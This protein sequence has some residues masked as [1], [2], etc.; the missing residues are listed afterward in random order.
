MPIKLFVAILILASVCAMPPFVGPSVAQTRTKPQKQQPQPN[1]TRYACPMHP[2]VTS[3]KPGKCPK[4]GMT[5]RATVDTG[6]VNAPASGPRAAARNDDG[7]SALSA[8]IPDVRVYDQNGKRL[9]FYSDLVKGKTVAI[10]FIFTTCTTICPPMTAT[11][12][13]VQQDMAG[14]PLHVELISVS[15]DPITDTP[16]RLRDFAAKFKAGPGWTF[17]TGDKTEID[18]LL[19]ALGAAVDDKNDHTPMIL[20]GNDPAGYWTRAYGLS[21]PAALVKVM[22]EAA[23]RK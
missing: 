16:E 1:A 6:P 2:E 7:L 8:R 12:R 13:R 15:V 23:N 18:S 20:V 14:L 21:S 10:N 4:C 19:Q 9:N 22:T 11:F 5:L 17:V 3:T